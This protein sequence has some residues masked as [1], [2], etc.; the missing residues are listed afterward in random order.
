MPFTPLEDRILVKADVI[1][2]QEEVKTAGS[3][4]IGIKQNFNE[5]ERVANTGVVVEAG[6]GRYEDGALVPCSVKKD[7]R[8]MWGKYSG[9]NVTIDGVELLVMRASDVMGI[10]S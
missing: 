10:I 4:I 7:D 2:M 3:S 8:I 1:A 9:S 5:S 6:P